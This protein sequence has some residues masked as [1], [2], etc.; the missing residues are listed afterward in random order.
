MF[1]ELTCNSYGAPLEVLDSADFVTCNHCSTWPAVRRTDN[2]T[3]TEQLDRLAKKTEEL[4][5]RL[6]NLNCQNYLETFD[7]EWSFEREEYMISGRDRVRSIPETRSSVV[8][9]IIIGVFGCLWTAMAVGITASAPLFGPFKVARAALPL[10]VLGG[11]LK[12]ITSYSNDGEYRRAEQRYLRWRTNLLSGQ[13]SS[14]GR[15][16]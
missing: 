2:I 1:E 5:E 10:F 3:F 7:R 16:E 9:G 8:D 13:S 11:V 14:T 12:S 6:D 4:R 15:S